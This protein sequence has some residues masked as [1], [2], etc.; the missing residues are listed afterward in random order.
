M[1]ELRERHLGIP[2][3]DP[4]RPRPSEQLLGAYQ[5]VLAQDG[6]S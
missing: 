1:D 6:P 5:R 2:R 4:A 3:P